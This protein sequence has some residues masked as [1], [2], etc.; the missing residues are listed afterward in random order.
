MGP[1]DPRA[2]PAPYRLLASPASTPPAACLS[3]GGDDTASPTRPPAPG[4]ARRLTRPGHRRAKISPG[5]VDM[6][7]AQSGPSFFDTVNL[8]FDKA[9]ALTD[10]PQ[11]LLDQIKVCN[12]VYAIQFPIRR[13]G[14][15]EVIAAW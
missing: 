2:A 15:Y 1:R 8:Y 7:T 4:G 14:G 9:A 11:G 3:A 13:N 10:Y 5:G 6:A 12:S